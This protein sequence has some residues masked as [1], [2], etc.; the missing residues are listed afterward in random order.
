MIKCGEILL[1]VIVLK[2]KLYFIGFWF[3]FL[4]IGI[5][6]LCVFNLGVWLFELEFLNLLVFEGEL[7]IVVELVFDDFL[8]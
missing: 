8:F 5:K 6:S 2:E 7:V 1:S 3:I 4:Y